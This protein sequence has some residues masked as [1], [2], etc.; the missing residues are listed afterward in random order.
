MGMARLG[1]LFQVLMVSLQKSPKKLLWLVLLQNSTEAFYV[2]VKAPKTA[3]SHRHPHT[4]SPN[5]SPY[6]SLKK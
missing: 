6:I 4:N 2:R 5:R 3:I 1:E